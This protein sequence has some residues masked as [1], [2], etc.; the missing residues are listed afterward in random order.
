MLIR[1]EWRNSWQDMR[2]RGVGLRRKD[3]TIVHK[4]ETG[5]GDKK[6][7]R[8]KGEGRRKAHTVDRKFTGA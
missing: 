7:I 4:K 1:K 3:E 8:K 2:S 5:S 6:E